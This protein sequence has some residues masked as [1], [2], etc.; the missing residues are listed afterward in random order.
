MLFF[1]VSIIFVSSIFLVFQTSIG[2][3]F[4]RV[5]NYNHSY[6]PPSPFSLELVPR[7][8]SILRGQ[9]VSII[10]KAKGT[11]PEFVSLFLKEERQE[12]Y[13]S[14][15]LKPDSN[16]YYVY[17]IPVLKN[18]IEF[19]AEADWLNSKVAANHGKIKVV[20]KPELRAI[21]GRIIYPHYTRLAPA[22][23]TEQNADF[24]ALRGSNIQISLL[25]NKEL[26]KAEIIIEKLTTKQITSDSVFTQ[27]DSLV[28]PMAVD[29]RKA[30]GSFSLSSTL[31]YYFIL[32]D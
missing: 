2:N 28:L 32:R 30:S 4:N 19:Y 21:S 22:S 9:T 7:D 20:D 8:S 27:K 23:F 14:Y 18:S 12:N 11:A 17:T 13:D 3:A 6:L 5:V 1:L 24:S 16:N 26:S 15:K 31:N 25:S 10:V 29:G